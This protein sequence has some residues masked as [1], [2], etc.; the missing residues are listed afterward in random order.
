MI[1]DNDDI[2][3]DN[4][5]IKFQK[6][7]Y[8]LFKSK[9]TKPLPTVLQYTLIWVLFEKWENKRVETTTNRANRTEPQVP[10]SLVSLLKWLVRRNF[11]Y[12]KFKKEIFLAW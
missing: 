5:N 4:K 9:K 12:L 3:V 11:S 8:F 1:V 10:A 6:I 7:V 2:R